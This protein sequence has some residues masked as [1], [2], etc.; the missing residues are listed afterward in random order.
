MST[1]R[2]NK[3]NELLRF[4][5]SQIL[6]KEIEAGTGVFVTVVRIEVSPTLEHATIYVSVF[7][8]N[9]EKEVM[10]KIKR[11]IYPIQQM[12]NKKLSMR[13]VPKVRFDIDR[14]EERASK[15]EQILGKIEK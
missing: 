15:I 13:P 8:D 14:S 6:H 7:P 1:N 9:K 4:E 2:L 5:V 12:L 10:Q 3:V 11:Q